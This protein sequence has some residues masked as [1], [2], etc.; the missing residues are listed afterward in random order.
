MF[1]AVSDWLEK[2]F[3]GSWLRRLL[4]HGITVLVGVL[5]GSS[6]PGLGVIAD[7][8]KENSGRLEEA[9]IAAILGL[10]ALWSS[11]K[12]EQKAEKRVQLRKKLY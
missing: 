12:N 4:R 10:W 3:L 7:I 2:T 9:V 11:E 8:I 5:V 6:I 1:G